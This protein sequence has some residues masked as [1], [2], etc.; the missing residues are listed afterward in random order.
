M[1]ESIECY[2]FVVNVNVYKLRLEFRDMFW[3][4]K[5]EKRT[6]PDLPAP[7]HDS[8]QIQGGGS[9]GEKAESNALP[10][11]PDSPNHNAFTQAA[12]KDA[13][14]TED[15]GR[16]PELSENRERRVLEMDE[17]H[18]GSE[19]SED[20]SDLG[21][22]KDIS[23]NITR[24]GNSKV[25]EVFVKISKFYSARRGLTEI[26][27]KL[28]DVDQLIKRIRETKMREEQELSIWEKDIAHVKSRLQDVNE[29]IFEK[30]E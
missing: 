6:L 30:V 26:Q 2:H 10:A 20:I 17:W 16:L 14:G 27:Q 4:K 24:L 1:S 25:S 28:E 29:N 3:G 11:F 12:I 9:E 15:E 21:E 22:P 7:P 13:V 19:G 23:P 5:E 8:I 18:P